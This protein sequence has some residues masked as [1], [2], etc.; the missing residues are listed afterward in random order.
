MGWICLRN[1]LLIF[2]C[3]C[4]GLRYSVLEGAGVADL[5]ISSR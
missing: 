3:S 1:S 4:A 5:Q 2:L